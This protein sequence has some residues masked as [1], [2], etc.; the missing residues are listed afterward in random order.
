MTQ[1]PVKIKVHFTCVEYVGKE[2]KGIY[3]NLP[4]YFRL[5]ENKFERVSYE[6]ECPCNDEELHLHM[7]KVVQVVIDGYIKKT[8]KCDI[9]GEILELS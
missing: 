9:K 6:D 3:S 2:I 4:N 7:F 5:T 8:F 1:F